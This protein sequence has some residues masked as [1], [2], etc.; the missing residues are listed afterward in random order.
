MGKQDPAEGGKHGSRKLASELSLVR[1]KVY[2]PI[3]KTTR[4]TSASMGAG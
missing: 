1:K 2:S 4:I 3:K